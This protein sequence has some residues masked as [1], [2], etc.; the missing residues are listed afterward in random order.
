MRY[1]KK[2]E[3]RFSKLPRG[4]WF[5]SF[6]ALLAWGY[7][8]SE[9]RD[10]AQRTAHQALNKMVENGLLEKKVTKNGFSK[11]GRSVYFKVKEGEK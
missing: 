9:I 10:E 2:R 1:S 6:E 8:N 5:K 7:K 3:E 4:R 11:A